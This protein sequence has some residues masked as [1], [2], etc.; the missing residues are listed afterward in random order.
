ME[1]RRGPSKG[2]AEHERRKPIKK[3]EMQTPFFPGKVNSSVSWR[4]GRGG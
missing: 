1:G 4:K 2:H 3:K